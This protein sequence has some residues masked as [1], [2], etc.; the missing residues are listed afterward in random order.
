MCV[1]ESISRIDLFKVVFFCFFI[2]TNFSIIAQQNIKSVETIN[3]AFPLKICYEVQHDKIE[4]IASDK[5]KGLTIAYQGGKIAKTG[6]QKNSIIWLSELGGEIVSDLIFEEKKIYLITKV[7]EVNFE[8]R[9]DKN[10]RKVNFILWSLNAETGVTNWRFLFTSTGYVFLN[11]YQDKIYL[12]EKDGNII[13]IRKND[14]QIVWSRKLTHEISSPPSLLETKIYVSLID[15]S[16]LALSTDNGEIVTKLSGLHSP[17]SF[18][19]ADVN[20]LFWGETKGSVNLINTSRNSYIWN[21]RYG[22]EIS[23]I[24]LTRNGILV[25]S[26]DNFAYLVSL[27]GGKK[28]WKRRLAG[29]ISVKPLIVGDFLIF[30]TEVNSNVTIMDLKN[31]KVVNQISLAGKG[32]ILATPLIISNLMVVL[33]NKGIFAFAEINADCS[34]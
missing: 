24:T 22:G 28:I 8:K 3:P 6:L 17:A 4:S 7:V 29:R 2:L 25:T 27:Q 20:K 15:N 9:K 13:S 16:I 11:S 32:F 14:A 33:T 31:G 18:L 34:H 30:I 5:K 21:M 23:S 1:F 26:L 12:T 19:I 10:K